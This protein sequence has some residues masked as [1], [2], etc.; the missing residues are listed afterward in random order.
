L[1]FAI[2]GRKCVHWVA[3]GLYAAVTLVAALQLV[4]NRRMNAGVE[5]RCF[6]CPLLIRLVER[7]NESSEDP[8]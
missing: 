3:S 7:M 6:R 2:R 4:A 8:D 1:H 5:L